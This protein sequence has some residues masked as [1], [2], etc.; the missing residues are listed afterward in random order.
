MNRL[1]T[2][3]WRREAFNLILITSPLWAY[4]VF[5]VTMGQYFSKLETTFFSRGLLL[6]DQSW[7]AWNDAFWRIL[8][9]NLQARTYFIVE[10]GTIALSLL[11]FIWMGRREPILSAYSPDHWLFA[12]FWFSPG[13]AS[14]CNN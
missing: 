7:M 6:F 4:L 3:A 2:P 1:L 13:D 12:D 14:L 10:F 9:D 11:A 5:E 8:S